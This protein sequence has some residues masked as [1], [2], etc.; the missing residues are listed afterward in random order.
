[1]KT[2]NQK[3][4]ELIRLS[5]ENPDLTIITMVAP[6]IVAEDSF[7]YWLGSIGEIR[8]DILWQ[9]DEYTSIGYDE[10]FDKLSCSF[11][12]DP[13]SEDLSDE[14]FKKIIDADIEAKK[15]CKDI[16]EAIIVYIELP[17]V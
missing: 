16:Y 17:G 4:K 10:I 8:K 11:E 12:D 6:E 13:E 14:E 7:K 15:E 5:E 2:D 3:I 1:M 9:N